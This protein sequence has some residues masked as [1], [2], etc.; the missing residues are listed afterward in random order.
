MSAFSYP[1]PD[2]NVFLVQFITKVYRKK[3]TV[4][5]RCA[6]MEDAHLHSIFIRNLEQW[7]LWHPECQKWQLE[8]FIVSLS[9]LWL[10]KFAGVVKTKVF[11]FVC[12]KKVPLSETSNLW[13]PFMTSRMLAFL[14]LMLSVKKGSAT[15]KYRL[16]SSVF[17][18]YR[19]CV[20]MCI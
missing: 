3:Q 17:V 9:V 13:S 7:E 16:L 4:L 11:R 20:Y 19:L 8:V 14:L 5:N 15:A 12:E 6:E 2:N 1:E 10:D 18:Y